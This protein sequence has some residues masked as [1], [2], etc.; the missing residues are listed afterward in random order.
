[1]QKPLWFVFQALG[2]RQ[3]SSI[4]INFFFFFFLLLEE[5]GEGLAAARASGAVRCW[6]VVSLAAPF[7]RAGMAVPVHGCSPFRALP[8]SG[9]DTALSVSLPQVPCPWL[10]ATSRAAC[11][12]WKGPLHVPPPMAKMLSRKG[13]PGQVSCRDET[14]FPALGV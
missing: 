6:G 10:F 11:A 9:Q 2:R 3:L 13:D 12:H 7:R 5:A 14:V 1:M 8:W 4:C